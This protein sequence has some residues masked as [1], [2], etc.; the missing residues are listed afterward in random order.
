MAYNYV[1]KRRKTNGKRKLKKL[2]RKNIR[3]RAKARAPL[4]T[5]V[6][7]VLRD[8]AETKYIGWYT[9]TAVEVG[10]CS[11]TGFHSFPQ[12][13]ACGPFN[14]DMAISQGTNVSER[15][16][17]RIRTKKYTVRLLVKPTA[18][19]TGIN[20][21]PRPFFLIVYFGYTKSMAN[22]LPS[23]FT[24]FYTSGDTD[25]APSG[26]IT[27]TWHH[28]NTDK[29]VIKKKDIIK[30]GAQNYHHHP[31][32][33]VAFNYANNDFPLIQ[34]RQYD[35]TK[36]MHKVITYDDNSTVP[37]NPTKLYMWMEAVDI[38]GTR[39]N[40]LLADVWLEHRYE[41]TDI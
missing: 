27:D 9:P 5:A 40:G 36:A 11:T 30:V 21:T 6:K 7:R 31:D 26:T 24:D 39:N 22:A 19:E 13:D 35:L 33:N 16:G 18:A 8:T 34:R 20:D 15:I 17:N 25:I 10:A 28:E 2:R 4:R 29:W 14:I 23:I 1:Y 38:T 12:V 3:R 41:Y 37:T 32:T